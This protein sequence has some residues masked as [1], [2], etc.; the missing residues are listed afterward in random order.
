MYEVARPATRSPV[1]PAPITEGV[2]R[3]A[4]VVRLGLVMKPR[5][6]CLH[7]ATAIV[8]SDTSWLVVPATFSGSPIRYVRTGILYSPPATPQD[9]LMIPI[10]RPPRIEKTSSRVDSPL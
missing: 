4:A 1:S 2:P 10:P 9:P 5:R 3:I 7:S 8:G 6:R